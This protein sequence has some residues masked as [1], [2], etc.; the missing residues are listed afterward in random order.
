MTAMVEIEEAPYVRLTT[1]IVNCEPENVQVGQNVRVTFKQ[2]GPAW[3]PLFE[4][5]L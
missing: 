5:D 4:P 1:Q 3:L 2:A